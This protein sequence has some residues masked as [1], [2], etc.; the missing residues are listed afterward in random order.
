M[1]GSRETE[2][3]QVCL[4]GVGDD[5]VRSDADEEKRGDELARRI[6]GWIG[7]AVGGAVWVGGAAMLVVVIKDRNG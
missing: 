6:F 4:R 2:E 7:T 1:C 3:G 5:A